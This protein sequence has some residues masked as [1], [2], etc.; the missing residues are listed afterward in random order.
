MNRISSLPFPFILS[1]LCLVLSGIV[2]PILAQTSSARPIS[3]P[4]TQVPDPDIFDGT[5][6]ENIQ[7]QQRKPQVVRVGDYS[8]GN[9]LE[10]MKNKVEGWNTQQQQQQGQGQQGQQQQGQQGQG[11]GQPGQQGEQQEQGQGGGGQQEGE[12][13]EG[14]QP[15]QQPGQGMPQASAT[16]I[17]NPQGQ[18][19]GQQGQGGMQG[20]QQGMGGGGMP[21]QQ[22]GG[23][24]G[25][26]N[27]PGG[28]MGGGDM[29]QGG[30][31][32]NN[33]LQIL[34]A[35]TQSAKQSMSQRK[36]QEGQ[37]GME[38]MQGEE[39]EFGNNSMQVEAANVS[40]E[41]LGQMEPTDEETSS[42]AQRSA[43]GRQEQSRGTGS[44]VG[45][46]IPSDI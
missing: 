20:Q 30:S 23:M 26:M 32:G 16:Q 6:V 41:T 40:Q 2:S 38:G 36:N 34:A 43:V 9:S 10:G 31:G 19:Q 42:S 29:Q 5:M 3:T 18:Q 17:E 1:G 25:S 39:G 8:E 28:M 14:Q 27:M 46:N 37:Q 33:P 13:G 22:Q 7:Q 21:G 44:E 15:G 11:Q 4:R 24:N 45:D 12:A 35:I